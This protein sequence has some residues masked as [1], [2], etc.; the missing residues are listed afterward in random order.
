MVLI[1][2]VI[3][4]V[5]IFSLLAILVTQINSFIASLLKWRSKQLKEGLIRLIADKQLQAE[6]LAHPLINMV[7]KSEL[8]LQSLQ[9]TA[10]QAEE[11]VNSEA[12]DV[13]YVDPKTFAEALISILVVR[14]ANDLYVPLRNAVEALPNGDH[15]DRLR[16]LFLDLQQDINDSK[17]RQIRRTV[18]TIPSNEAILTALD[19]TEAA[20]AT[21]RYRSEELAPLLAGARNIDSPAFR[22][23]L[24]V[25]LA[26]AKNIDD[27]RRKFETWFNDG[28]SRTS[29]LYQNKLQILSFFVGLLLVMILNVDTMAIGRALWEDQALRQSVAAAAREF[30]PTVPTTPTAP[31]PDTSTLPPDTTSQDPAV[32]EENAVATAAAQDAME[33]IEDQIDDIEETVQQLL[34]LQLP[35]GWESFAVTEDMVTTASALGLSDPRNNTR[36][37]WNLMPGNNVGWLG[38]WIQKLLGWLTAAVAAAKG[39]PFWFDLLNKIAR[40]G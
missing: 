8:V 34:E 39:A 18:E 7:D 13:A 29:E 26:T 38:L 2:V 33:E 35:I 10:Q 22:N 3:G 9:V 6:I 40:R 32:S 25:L 20:F 37:L 31:D 36:N 4:L 11:I 1:E 12:T 28:M 23:A 14:A 19:Q 15:K 16:D 24:E 27:A 5:F 17:L 21:I 30:E